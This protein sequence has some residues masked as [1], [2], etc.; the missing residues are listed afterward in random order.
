MNLRPNTRLNPLEQP[1]NQY[2]LRSLL[3]LN[4]NAKCCWVINNNNN[5]NNKWCSWHTLCLVSNLNGKSCKDNM[6]IMKLHTGFCFLFLFFLFFCWTWQDEGRFWFAFV[7]NS[8]VLHFTLIQGS[9]TRSLALW[10]FYS[11]ALWLSVSF[12]LLEL[13]LT[14]LRWLCG[15]AAQFSW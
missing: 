7:L 1:W 5:Y 13:S 11:L 12:L 10:L 8:A 6:L 15:H 9:F 2:K 4:L 3:N 14:R